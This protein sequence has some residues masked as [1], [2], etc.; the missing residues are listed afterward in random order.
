MEITKFGLSNFRVFKNHTDFELAPIMVLTGPNNSGKSSLIKALL[1]LKENEKNINHSLHW[2]SPLNYFSGHHDLGNHQLTKNLKEENTYF[3]FTFFLGYKF[4]IG[5]KPDGYF[6]WDYMIWNENN[7]FIIAQSGAYINFNVS[8][9]IRYFQKRLSFGLSSKYILSEKSNIDLKLIK[10]LIL[11]ISE[12]EKNFWSVDIDIITDFDFQTRPNMQK[13][14]DDALNEGIFTTI[15][16]DDNS[17]FHPEADDAELQNLLIYLFNRITKVRLNENEISFLLPTSVNEYSNGNNFFHF[18]ELFYIGALREPLKRLYSRTDQSVFQSFFYETIVRKHSEILSKPK[19][20]NSIRTNEKEEENLTKNK[21]T[22]K[23]L[24][25]FNIGE[26]LSYGYNKEFDFFYLTLD[27]KALP[28]NGFGFS[29]IL[30]LLLALEKES[31]P[32]ESFS[33]D[34]N[35]LLDLPFSIKSKNLQLS[36]PPTIIIEEPETGLHP[37]FQSKIA[38]LIVDIQ[39]TFN[40]NIIVETHS[41]YFIRKLQYLTATNKINPSDAVIYYFNNPEEIPAGEKQIKKIIIEKDGSLTD[42]FGPGFIDEGTNLKFEL[43]RI[44][45]DRKN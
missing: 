36:F 34:E 22:R 29:S 44:N 12:F 17:D 40:V 5:I 14:K 15:N 42:N 24:K 25:E 6:D 32:F 19:N 4:V 16:Y 39:R 33:M 9:L 21:F 35:L 13:Y 38:E 28:E 26:T 2:E 43:L 20:Q 7:E 3:S 11:E 10:K 45:R 18:S 30:H 37:A 41:E 31:L 27:D 8:R 23:W 1:L